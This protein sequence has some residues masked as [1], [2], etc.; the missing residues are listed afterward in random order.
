MD[1]ARYAEIPREMVEAG[2]W[3]TPR[4]NYLDYVEKPPLGYWLTAASYKT[5]GVSEASARLP[6]ALVSVLGLLGVFWLGSWLWSQRT[7]MTAA[8]LLAGSGLY[9]FLSQYIT[10]DMPLT[11]SLLWCSGLILRA[12]MRPEDAR[13]AGPCAW[14]CAA[15]AALSKGLVGLVFPLGWTLALLLLY[16]EL[17]RGL[18]GLLHP[19]GPVL[20]FA[21]AAPWFVLMERLHPGFLRVFFIEHHFQRY[22]TEKYNR[23]SPWWFFLLVLPAGILPWTAP[24]VAGLWRSL[25]GW[26]A[27]ARGGALTVWVLMILAFFSTS[28][29]KL[30]TYILP[31]IPQLSLLAA[32]DLDGEPPR[33]SPRLAW[34]LIL[35]GLVLGGLSLVA[36]R[37]KA[38]LVSAKT[39]SRAVLER[40][41]PGDLVYTYGT[42]LHSLPF[43]T[44]RRVDK[45]VNWVGELNYSKRD[46]ANSGRF[47]DDKDIRAFPLA[48]RRVFVALRRFEEPYFLT[49]TA[50]RRPTS[51]E[52]FGPW[53][54]AEY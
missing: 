2:D 19:L 11:V 52:R 36:I 43:Y 38:D 32:R 31:V 18:K 54:L 50:P 24:A 6:L 28:Q 5:F 14:A 8:A 13:W 27:D 16:P 12:L 48:G 10:P 23:M 41:G 47:G 33:W 40:R 35:A 51:F 30:A 26:R 46:P 20:F 37:W 45:T 3:A 44:G 4:L 15:L 29:S 17:R 34:A 53:T 1:D 49:L 42:Y 39:L 21:I 7:G 9:F 25:R 22:L